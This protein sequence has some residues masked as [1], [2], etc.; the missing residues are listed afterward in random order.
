LIDADL[1]EQEFVAKTFTQKPGARTT[2]DKA[3][4]AKREQYPKY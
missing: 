3:Q 2:S 1:I 4:L